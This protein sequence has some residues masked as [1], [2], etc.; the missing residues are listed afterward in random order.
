MCQNC[1][2]WISWLI[3]VCATCCLLNK[4]KVSMMSLCSTAAP[5]CHTG[6]SKGR[7]HKRECSVPVIVINVACL[8]CLKAPKLKSP[9]LSYICILQL[10]A[11]VYYRPKQ[12]QISRTRAFNPAVVVVDL[13]CLNCL[14]A[15][16]LK[17]PYLGYIRILQL[18]AWVHFLCYFKCTQIFRSNISRM[19][20]KSPKFILSVVLHSF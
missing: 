7:Y 5:D 18:G 15:P 3:G 4:P 12:R 11:W 8:N 10:C 13:A 16:K 2:F 14:K 1:C 9:Y 17:S 20:V 19:S 6:Q